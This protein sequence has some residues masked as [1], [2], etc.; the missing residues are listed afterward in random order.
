MYIR[1]KLKSKKHGECEAYLEEY[2]PK[3]VI[4]RRTA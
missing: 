2:K 4:K 3:L 1:K